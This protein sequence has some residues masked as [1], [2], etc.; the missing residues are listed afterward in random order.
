[1]KVFNKRVLNVA[2]ALLL[3]VFAVVAAEKGQSAGHAIVKANAYI[4]SF[5]GAYENTETIDPSGV[6]S[7]W[8]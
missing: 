7:V 3:F 4:G 6:Y 5:S 2:V 1:L 8:P